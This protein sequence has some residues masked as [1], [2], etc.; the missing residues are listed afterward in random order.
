MAGGAS[1]CVPSARAVLLAFCCSASGLLVPLHALTARAPSWPLIA[2]H[3]EPSVAAQVALAAFDCYHSHSMMI[4]TRWD[5]LLPL[6]TVPVAHTFTNP[7][8]PA[9]QDTSHN[10]SRE[11]I[12]FFSRREDRSAPSSSFAT[13]PTPWNSLCQCLPLRMWPW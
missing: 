10:F 9:Q 3:R 5:I 11:G 12:R 2:T 7:T 4:L 8:A 1:S 6:L 13:T